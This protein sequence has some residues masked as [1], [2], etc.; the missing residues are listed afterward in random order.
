LAKKFTI[1]VSNDLT[2]TIHGSI[3]TSVYREYAKYYQEGGTTMKNIK[4]LFAYIFSAIFLLDPCSYAISFYPPN[5]CVNALAV[6]GDEIF[7]GTQQGLAVWNRLTGNHTTY[8]LDNGLSWACIRSLFV[9]SHNIVWAGT[10]A[11]IVK[12]DGMNWNIQNTGL[13]EQDVWGIVEDKDGILWFASGR[14]I[15]C[16]DGKVWTPIQDYY[17]PDAKT[18]PTGTYETAEYFVYSVAV[19]Q[20]NV[21]WFATS[22]GVLSFDGSIWKRYTTADGLFNNQVSSIVVDHNNVKWFGSREDVGSDVGYIGGL[23]RYDGTAWKTYTVNDGLAAAG[24]LS[25]AV[26]KDNALWIGSYGGLTRF[27]G[28]S[29]KSYFKSDGLPNPAV[30]SIAVDDKNTAWI[31]TQDGLAS[32]DLNAWRIYRNTE[33][34]CIWYVSEIAVDK[35]NLKWFGSREGGINSFD[36]KTWINHSGAQGLVDCKVSSI[37]V[38]PDN[39]KWFATLE[40]G[41]TRY[42]NDTWTSF[43][44]S[45]SGIV[46]NRVAAVAVDHNN[47][48]WLSVFQGAMSFDGTKWTLY[49]F[50]EEQQEFGL[51]A[52]DKNNVKWF[53]TREGLIRFDGSTWQHIKAGEYGFPGGTVTSMHIDRT[54]VL[55][56]GYVSDPSYSGI[57]KF[58]GTTFK[59]Y[60]MSDGLPDWYVSSIASDAANTIWIT[61][62]RGAVSRFDGTSWKNM[63][64]GEM[65][66][67]TAVDLNNVMWFGGHHNIFVFDQ[68]M[69]KLASMYRP[70]AIE[71]PIQPSAIPLMTNFPNP[72]NPSTTITYTL[73]KPGNIDLKIYSV[74]GQKVRALKSGALATGIHSIVWDGRNEEGIAVSSGIYIALL[75]TG[76]AISSRKMMLIR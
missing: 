31:G 24:V 23:T 34:M 54:N 17:D 47:L 14:G 58:D 39:V 28:V 2:I 15:F 75:Q 66:L 18:T 1:S 53:G 8:L 36:G 43:T 67:S 71:E 70:S 65:M 49:P 4:F 42:D 76:N 11:G 35:D 61:T 55:W 68:G 29:W 16:Y 32:F 7:V 9:D 62:T 50:S 19:D 60:T 21:K 13:N 51:I 3:F 10:C 44:T 63:N 64:V 48:V 52:V 38:G 30:Q 33:G 57:C 12:Y 56:V 27:D 45:N 20:D 25:L 22:S 74:T 37:A 72:F 6:K 46:N 40:G 26:A 41:L 59:R 5:N 73:D 69:L